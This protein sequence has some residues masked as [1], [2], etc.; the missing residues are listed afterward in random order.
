MSCER[1]NITRQETNAF[2]EKL[3]KAKAE[4][5]QLK[6]N[7]STR[8]T[9]VLCEVHGEDAQGHPCYVDLRDGSHS[10]FL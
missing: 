10:V 6:V 4:I 3:R 9:H 2:A 8:G 1:C 5:H 7:P